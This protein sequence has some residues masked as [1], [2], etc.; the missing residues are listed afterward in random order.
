MPALRKR[1]AAAEPSSTRKRPAGAE[2]RI[3]EEEAK[4]KRSSATAASC[5]CSAWSGNSAATLASLREEIAKSTGA[6]DRESFTVASLSAD[7]SSVLGVDFPNLS[8]V[9]AIVG[10]KEKEIPQLVSRG[11]G[12]KPAKHVY[13]LGEPMCLR[14]GYRCSLRDSPIDVLNWDKPVEGFRWRFLLPISL[15]FCPT[16]LL[17]DVLPAEV[18]VPDV[19]CSFGRSSLMSRG[20]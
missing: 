18:I 17:I 10:A 16:L 19:T 7:V 4:T 11:A 2:P 5:V 14:H 9:A 1:P 15:H 3:G 6:D 13:V 20:A 8:Y 12:A